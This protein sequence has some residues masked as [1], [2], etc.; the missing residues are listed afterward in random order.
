VFGAL[1]SD[2]GWLSPAYLF[3]VGILVGYLWFKFR[4]GKTFAM[5]LYP[6]FAFCILFWTGFNVMFDGRVVELLRMAIAL[7]IYD[8]LTLRQIG[9]P[10]DAKAGVELDRFLPEPVPQHFAGDYF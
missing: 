2:L 8:R 6:W 7:T 4:A 5:V 9:Q 3:V 1:Y 10:E